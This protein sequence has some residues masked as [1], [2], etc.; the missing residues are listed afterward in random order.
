[1]FEYVYFAR[2]DSVMDG[3]SV[4]DARRKA[5]QLLAK[6]HGVDADIVAPVPDTAAVAASSYAAA[7]GIPYVDVLS[8]NRYIGRTF[9]QPEQA[10]RENMVR[11]KLTAIHGNVDGK[12]IILID[13]S[14]VRGT[15]SK[16]IIALLRE[17]GAKE[18]HLRITSPPVKHACY[19]GIDIQNERELIGANHTESEI[20]DIIGCDSVQYLTVDELKE[21]CSDA[22]HPICTGCFSGN[23]PLDIK[24]YN[25]DKLRME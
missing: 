25:I 13:D 22:A 11:I 8:K 19:F 16:K 4:Y 7:T 20:A 9:I 6:Y 2:T 5:G 18:I 24:G 15:T 3:L 12:R 14:I 1:M 23:Y 21:M 17:A 10:Q